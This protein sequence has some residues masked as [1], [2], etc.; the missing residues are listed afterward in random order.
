MVDGSR[1]SKAMVNR[2]SMASADHIRKF[3]CRIHSPLRRN[4]KHF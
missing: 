4:S 2:I 1:V 3:D